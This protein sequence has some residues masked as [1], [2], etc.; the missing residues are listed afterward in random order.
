MLDSPWLIVTWAVLGPALA[1]CGAEP[2]EMTP[3]PE[4]RV[5]FDRAATN[6]GYVANRHSDTISV[7]DLDTMTLVG[8]S[9]VGLDP[10]EIDGPR[11]VIID[12]ERHLA[13]VVLSYPLA[14][15][16]A[17]HQED[18]QR[19]YVQVLSTADLRPLGELVVDPSATD[20]A[21]SSDGRVLAVSH[22][23]EQRAL[24]P[25]L[26]L[27]ARRA[28]LALVEPAAAIPSGTASV[29]WLGVCIAPSAVVFD[30]T[31]AR[32][33]V[34][35]TGEDSV[36]VVDM[37]SASVIARVPAGE[38]TTNKPFSLSTNRSR[39]KLVLSNQVAGSV[40]VLSMEDTPLA[41][42]TTFVSGIPF[43]AGWLDDERFVVPVQDPDGAVL[44][45]AADGTIG[46]SKRYDPGACDK[47]GH[48]T[49]TADRRLYL[50]CEGDQ[51]QPGRVVQL[52]PNT[53]E[54]LAGVD[55]GIYP[56]RLELVS[57]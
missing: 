32:A 28:A 24:A 35:C 45:D 50:V 54:I 13:Y 46:I 21:L 20:I 48:A 8:S 9:A 25:T 33:F 11:H 17:H 47:P 42:S 41:L 52:D 5:Q 51:Y 31:G 57:P 10:V 53:L 30:E 36:A 39:A 23:D 16:N 12:R 29:R 19:G 22:F 56:D 27:E 43:Q 14:V 7:V 40:V 1:G 49:S 3:F 4:R 44:V 34:A 55:V 15:A 2:S 26:G 38:L 6:L 37:A 18:E